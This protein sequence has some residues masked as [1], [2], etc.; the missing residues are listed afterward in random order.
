MDHGK[1][2]RLL[3]AWISEN[4]QKSKLTEQQLADM[5][6]LTKTQIKKI[7]S[8]EETTT[9]GEWRRIANAL[10]V[11]ETE[12]EELTTKWGS[13]S[14]S[15]GSESGTK[16]KLKLEW[17]SSVPTVWR[18][19]LGDSLFELAVVDVTDFWYS[20]LTLNGK[21][22]WHFPEDYSSE[23]EAKAYAERSAYRVLHSAIKTLV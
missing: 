4:R 11:N 14:G 23:D 22:V 1:F 13:Q 17:T 7:E 6:G 5:V 2:N 3:G 9:W 19:K 21:P 16:S 20:Y 18:A 10:G 8:G 15:A 12:A